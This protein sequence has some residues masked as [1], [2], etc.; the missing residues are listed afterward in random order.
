MGRV[1]ASHGN[2]NAVVARDGWPVD[3]DCNWWL[4]R[5]VSLCQTFPR[6]GINVCVVITKL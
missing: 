1:P 5:K 6:E 2:A 4:L 3:A